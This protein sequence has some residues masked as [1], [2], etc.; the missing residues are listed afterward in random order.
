MIVWLIF[1]II[2]ANFFCLYSATFSCKFGSFMTFK[3][4]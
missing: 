2:V 4:L 1:F 3:Y